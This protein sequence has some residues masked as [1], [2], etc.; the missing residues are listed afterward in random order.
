M[1]D[2]AVTAPPPEALAL[3]PP[4]EELRLSVATDIQL[5]GLYGP[6]WLLA[7][8]QRLLA[9]SPEGGGPPDIVDLPLSEV[10]NLEIQDLYGSGALKVR[11]R[12]S[13][14][15]VA[16]SPRRSVC[17]SGASVSICSPARPRS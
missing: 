4:D 16:T 15:I 14:Q 1:P 7:T 17:C 2:L 3:L 8:D 12:D 11:T 5:D 6:A 13:G 9:Y 10:E